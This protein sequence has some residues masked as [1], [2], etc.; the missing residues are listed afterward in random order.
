MDN[1]Q[2]RIVQ[3]GQ[4]SKQ[5]KIKTSMAP[6]SLSTYMGLFVSVE[7]TVAIDAVSRMLAKYLIIGGIDGSLCIVRST[8]KQT[9]KKRN[10]GRQ[11]TNKT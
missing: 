2:R 11:E 6:S 7:D 5:I 8:A 4:K 9:N 3:P 1:S 10:K